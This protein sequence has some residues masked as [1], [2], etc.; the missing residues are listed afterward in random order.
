MIV[1]RVKDWDKHFE[2]NKSRERDSCS[3]VCV[4]N[5]HDGF[6]LALVLTEQ[7]GAAIYGIFCLILGLCS[8]QRLPRSGWLTD[9]GTESG[10]PFTPSDLS[11]LF[12][13]PPSEIENAINTIVSKVG[14]IEACERTSIK[15]PAKR[16]PS[17]N[18]VPLNGREENRK[19]EK[20]LSGE[21]AIAASPLAP[22][23][24]ARKS[25]DALPATGH[26][27]DRGGNGKNNDGKDTNQVDPAYPMFPVIPSRKSGAMTWTLTD[28]HLKELAETFTGVN[29]PAQARKAWLWCK[30]NPHRRK[31]ANGMRNFM[32]N[33][34]ERQ[35]NSGHTKGGFAGR[36]ATPAYANRED[37]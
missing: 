14:W 13:R 22:D 3:Y 28:D 16:P 23:L 9:D 29:V 25:A 27:S 33:W 7:N 26:G 34:M 24:P 37:R 8:R 31:T 11:I 2:N 32:R 18:E 6:G 4:P 19:E 17:A 1:Y 35:Q 12:R 5:K 36:A 15:V 21:P 20:E 10:R 30:D